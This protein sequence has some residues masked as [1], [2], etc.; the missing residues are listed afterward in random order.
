MLPTPRIGEVILYSYL[1]HSEHL[2]GLE[3]GCKDRPCAVLLS[4]ESSDGVTEVV[5]LPVTHSAPGAGGNAVEIPAISKQRLGLDAERSWLVLD[6]A[7]RF[8]WP[9]PDIRPFDGPAG[10]TVSLGMLPPK[11]FQHVRSR[12]VDLARSRKAQITMRTD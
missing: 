7:N 8:V 1:W 4:V 11:F 5:V 9:G 3:E 6:D 12:F 10:S 2:A